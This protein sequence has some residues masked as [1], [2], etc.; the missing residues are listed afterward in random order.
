LN[1]NHLSQIEADHIFSEIEF[2]LRQH[3]PKFLTNTHAVASLQSIAGSNKS[4]ASSSLYQRHR[5]NRPS[6]LFVLLRSRNKKLSCRRE[7]SCR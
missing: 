5:Y 4:S 7:A 1:E 3:E 2:K 6:P